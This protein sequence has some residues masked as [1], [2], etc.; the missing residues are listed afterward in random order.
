[1]ALPPSSSRGDS[2]EPGRR[3]RG[4]SYPV[5]ADGSAGCDRGGYGAGLS[6]FAPL[7]A[8]RRSVVCLVAPLPELASQAAELSVHKRR[9]SGR[10]S[11]FTRADSLGRS[12]HV[13]GG[14]FS[15]NSKS[16]FS[17]GVGVRGESRGPPPGIGA[18]L[19]S[20]QIDRQGC[21]ECRQQVGG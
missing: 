1:M 16:F 10:I 2:L 18:A 13:L 8:P 12:T 6:A 14:D 4:E 20:P 21:H 9:S 19:R 5:S 17:D 11:D 3:G 7:V 15:S